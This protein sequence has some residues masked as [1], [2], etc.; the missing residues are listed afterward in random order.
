MSNR[1]VTIKCAG[2]ERTIVVDSDLFDDIQLEACTR[3]I[4]EEI[5]SNSPK[6]APFIIS[7]IRKKENIC[8]S[9]KI[10]INAGE[11]LKAEF[12]RANFFKESHVDLLN[13]PLKSEK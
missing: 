4:E 2:W 3:A 10:L 7:K 5:K 13:E 9:Y 1:K 8:N 12:L 11:H 6:V